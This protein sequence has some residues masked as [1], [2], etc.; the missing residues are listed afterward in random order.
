MF[1]ALLLDARIFYRYPKLLIVTAFLRIYHFFVVSDSFSRRVGRLYGLS[2]KAALEIGTPFHVLD[3]VYAYLG[4]SDDDMPFVD[5]GC[6][7][8]NLLWYVALTRRSVVMGVEKNPVVADVVH[9]CMLRMTSF[10]AFSHVRARFNIVVGDVCDMPL[11]RGVYWLAWT[12][13]SDAERGAVVDSLKRLPVGAVVVTT[14]YPVVGDFVSLQH[15]FRDSFF[16]GIGT[17]YVYEVV[18]FSTG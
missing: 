1:R 2:A 10:E 18:G 9:R 15:R 11:C 4:D 6:G 8:G 17:V 3:R 13:F 14:T 5:L 16:W 12:G 7:Y